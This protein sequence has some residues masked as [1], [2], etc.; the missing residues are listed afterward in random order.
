MPVSFKLYMTKQVIEQCKNCGVNNNDPKY[1]GSHCAIA[2]LLSDLFPNV[3]VSSEYIYP[4][5]MNDQRLSILLPK[6][7]QDFIKIFDSFSGAPRLR[8]MIPEF[9]FSIDIPDAI[10]SMIDI[11]SVFK[12]PCAIF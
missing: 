12:T 1:V 2:V 5:G 11:E 10:I 6:I 9:E 8:K 3:F 7:A 4:F